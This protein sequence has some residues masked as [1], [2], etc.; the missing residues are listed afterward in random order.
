MSEEGLTLREAQR[1]IDAWIS[2]YQAGYWPPLANLVYVSQLGRIP[3]DLAP[4]TSRAGQSPTSARNRKTPNA[5]RRSAC[6]SGSRAYGSQLRGPPTPSYAPS[7]ASSA[8]HAVVGR[9]QDRNE[10]QVDTWDD[11]KRTAN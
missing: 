4:Y 2:Q 10:E 5:K 8:S 6:S 9:K 7:T 1:R 11:T 3:R